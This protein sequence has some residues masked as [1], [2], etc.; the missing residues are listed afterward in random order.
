MKKI[1]I[2][3]L[4][5]NYGGTEK[6]ICT[7]A[8][9]LSKKYDVTICSFYKLLDKSFFELNSNIKVD[10]L[11]T[12]IVPN[13]DKVYNCLKQVK[14][15]SLFKEAVK[16]IKILYLKRFRMIKYIKSCN[17]DVIISSRVLYDKYLG[18]YGKN[19]VLKIGWEHNH[20]NN[21]KYYIRKM[22]RNTKRLDYLVVVSL[23]LYSFYSD[24]LKCKCMYIPN[25]IDFFPKN[26][27]KLTSK[28][29]ICVGR[30]SSEKGY[31]DLIKVFSIINKS[32]SD[33][34]LD[35]VGDGICKKN[36]L[37]LIKEYKLESR[38]ILHGEQNKDYIN[39]LLE[40]S[41]LY[42]TCSYKESFGISVVEAF[43]FG[44]PVIAFSDA[45]GL[46]EIITDGYDGYLVDNR[47][48]VEYANK[49][50]MLM[51]DD[52]LRKKL[53]KNAINTSRKYDINTIENRWFNLIK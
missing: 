49:A 7:L 34:F 27:S 20:H 47:D 21:N 15:I 13:R 12:G 6:M 39:K 43:S 9:C 38:V 23:E 8:N 32:R 30:L 52:D 4:H 19:N 1:T 22:K 37:K 48:Y 44:V 3:A 41:S 46:F 14:L 2:L 17:S 28:R 31:D 40:D 16:S 26:Y 11:T 42:L 45:G 33:F 25:G 29:C 35:I 36:I 24:I 10:Y 18:R 5:L 51:N 53:G 50:I